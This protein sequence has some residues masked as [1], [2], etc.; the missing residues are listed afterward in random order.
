MTPYAVSDI[1]GHPEKLAKALWTAGLTDAEGNWSGQ[2][3]RLWFL[4]DFF[5]R[6][7]DGIGVLALVRRLAAQAADQREDADAVRTPVEE[8]A[9]EPEP[10]VVIRPVALGVDQAGRLEC[11]GQLLGVTVDVTDRVRRGH[12]GV[13][14][15]ASARS[16]R[17]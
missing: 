17:R 9:E 8:V 15:E 4:G 16:V 12:A 3:V 7:P 5:D 11:L 6:G 13:T 2:D 14:L 10:D 1:H